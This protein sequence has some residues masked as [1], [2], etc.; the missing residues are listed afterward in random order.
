MRRLL[1]RILWSLSKRSVIHGYHI[2]FGVADDHLPA[3]QE[4]VAAAIGLL[5]AAHPRWLRRMRGYVARI[6]IRQLV[7][8]V[9][10][11]HR[12]G[13]LVELDEAYLCRPDNTIARIASTL[14]HELTHARIDAVGIRYTT[15]NRI[16]VER[17]CIAQE[18]A[19]V[20]RLPDDSEHR[21]LL[22]ELEEKW[23]RAEDLWSEAAEDARWR[24]A[25][26][27]IRIPSWLVTG[28]WWVRQAG[29]R[30]RSAA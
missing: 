11:W 2:G 17:A 21:L 4:R 8:S 28:L 16:R 6:Q 22:G 1:Q 7:A 18:M 19:F 9:G 25:V 12:G 26:Q 29:R 15:R 13:R 3:A 10:V 20:R 5:A 24:E 14:V 30:L 27:T 23:A